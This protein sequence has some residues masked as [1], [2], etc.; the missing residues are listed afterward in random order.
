MGVKKVTIVYK[1]TTQAMTTYNGFQ[2]ELGKWYKKDG[3]GDLCGPGFLHCYSDP[4]LA[5]LL[6]PTHADIFNPR[7][8]KA[9]A[10]GIARHDHG[11]KSGYSEMRLIKEIEI[12]KLQIKHKIAFAIYCAGEVCKKHNGWFTW[13]NNWLTGK[14]R[15]NAAAVAVTAAAPTAANDAFAAA[16]DA[17]AADADADAAA[18]AAAYAVVVKGTHPI[19]FIAILD[20]VYPIDKE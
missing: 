9:E 19:D 8:F 2:W 18:V 16:N 12:P 10:R 6:N 5:I 14:D 7:L 20:K 4:R 17:F 1:L 3:Q 13:A 11:L 15:S